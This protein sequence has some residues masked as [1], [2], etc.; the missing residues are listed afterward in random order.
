M[1]ST[2]RSSA[3]IVTT[4]SP[5]QAS[6]TRPA[7]CAPRSTSAR[8]L[9]SVRLYTVTSWPA[10]SRFAAIPAP[11]C[12]SPM[13]PTFMTPPLSGGGARVPADLRCPPG[14]LT[15]GGAGSDHRRFP[16]QHATLR[17]SVGAAALA[18]V[19]EE[20]LDP[21]RRGRHD[22]RAEVTAIAGWY[23]ADYPGRR[24]ADD[25]AG[26]VEGLDGELHAIGWQAGVHVVHVAADD[27]PRGARLHLIFDP[28]VS[29]E[30][31]LRVVRRRC[32]S[33]GDRHH[34]HEHESETN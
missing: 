26:G 18:P 8:S 30:A 29:I 17:V 4:A 34:G 21:I 10:P 3:S 27:G 31:F 24:G 6:A 14:R 16:Q 9:P 5:W 25:L 15:R 33:G 20:H 22:R 12:P 19:E 13:N 28:E 2:A 23:T 11:M 1:P 7:A 32:S